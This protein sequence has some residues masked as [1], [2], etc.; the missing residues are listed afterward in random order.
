MK[1][2]I[3][4]RRGIENTSQAMREVHYTLRPP[5][6]QG[7]RFV[8]SIQ[9]YLV[10]GS[11]RLGGHGR[12]GSPLG[13]G[14]SVPDAGGPPGGAAHPWGR[15]RR[16]KRAYVRAPGR[17][18]NFRLGCKLPRCGRRDVAK[19]LLIAVFHII[20][21]RIRKRICETFTRI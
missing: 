10:G 21:L 20:L 1:F 5:A 11:G 7:G 6:A 19:M 15:G 14:A 17:P 4:L 9:T 3:F 18:S 8:R 13:Q 12:S 2:R 16:P